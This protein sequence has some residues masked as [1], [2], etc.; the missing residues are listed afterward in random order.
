MG[1]GARPDWARRAARGEPVQVVVRV[2][3]NGEPPPAS[4][5]RARLAPRSPPCPPSSAAPALGAPGSQPPAGSAADGTARKDLIPA[6]NQ[7]SVLR[8]GAVQ[9]RDE[10]DFEVD[11]VFGEDATAEDIQER[12]LAKLVAQ[13]SEGENGAV[14]CFGATGTG[15]THTLQG[16]LREGEEGVV[17]LSIEALMRTLHGKAKAESEKFMDQRSNS[18]YDFFVEASFLE[19]VNDEVADMLHEGNRGLT[20]HEDTDRGF[21]VK[22]LT[23]RSGAM[24]KE[25][26]SDFQAGCAAR[27][28]EITDIGPLDERSAGVYTITIT[29]YLPADPDSP[30]GNQH[31]VSS[32]TFVDLP[33]SERLGM[34]REVLRAQEGLSINRP[35]LSF[36]NMVRALSTKGREDF[37]NYEESPLTKI[38]SEALGGNCNTLAIGTVRDG[39]WETSLNTLQ[40]LGALRRVQNFPTKNSETNRLLIRKYRN[41]TVQLRDKEAL[42]AAQLGSAPAIGD[43][44]ESGIMQARL[45]ELERR[46]IEEREGA[47]QAAQEIEVLQKRL[48]NKHTDEQDQMVEKSEL[49]EALIKS[50]QS[51]LEVNRA[52]I[53]LQ[54][55]F[56]SLET[57]TETQKFELEQRIIHLEAVQ[58]ESEVKEVEFRRLQSELEKHIEELTATKEKL[59]S[60]GE[61]L[62]HSLEGMTKERD[63]L[64]GELKELEVAKSEADRR[65]EEYE[66]AATS[67]PGI[68]L[69]LKERS[70]DLIEARDQMA[71]NQKEVDRI[72]ADLTKYKMALEHTRDRHAKELNDLMKQVADLA[73]AVYLWQ[74]DPESNLKT[75]WEDLASHWE[76]LGRA[77]GDVHQGEERTLRGELEDVKT[78]YSSLVN[79][80]RSLYDGYREIRYQ[81]EDAGGLNGG[82]HKIIHE[83]DLVGEQ[84]EPPPGEMEAR[85]EASESKDESSQLRR[86]LKIQTL[87]NTVVNDLAPGKQGE[88]EPTRKYDILD[89]EQEKVIAEGD[90]DSNVVSLVTENAK[91]REQVEAMKSR[92]PQTPEDTVRR[93]NEKLQARIIE[94]ENMD[95]SRAQM[96][97]EI[98]NLKES[99]SAANDSAKQHGPDD[100]RRLVKD[101]TMTTQADLEKEVV[102]WQTRCTMAEEQLKS[103]EMYLSEATVQYQKEIMRLREIAQRHEPE[104]VNSRLFQAFQQGGAP[105]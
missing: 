105:N 67:L 76:I 94:M 26:I 3:A 70:R 6:R 55:D 53:D 65:A 68:E 1:A 27:T 8:P 29:Q 44:S 34:D 92:P 2:K 97:I 93:E 31:M 52:M 69:Q 62:S 18:A 57:E 42:L 54:L 63:K 36:G 16:R 10:D 82:T 78:R 25:L 17:Q 49:Q 35:L 89:V 95:R 14:L 38:L 102:L 74:E 50:E 75:S 87:K 13:V 73:K 81:I 28:S 72:T 21:W 40:Y 58:V 99:L 32:L 45:N 77:L 60:T 22:G 51:R 48:R 64:Q 90:L 91:L 9:P 19:I 12:T 83:K 61:E 100:I 56:N 88:G 41:R 59:E 24:G 47:A 84:E 66:E 5:P 96:A 43:P 104:N 4:P 23:T 80:F 46:L 85:R 86:K 7:V 37:V 103:S 20:V 33:G 101:F 79:R 11:Y 39:E 15:K 71:E 98:A 30:F